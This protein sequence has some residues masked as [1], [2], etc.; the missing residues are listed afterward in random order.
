MRVGC[1]AILEVG[2]LGLGQTNNYKK[3]YAKLPCLT[4]AHLSFN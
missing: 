1:L 4:L 3:W 2:L